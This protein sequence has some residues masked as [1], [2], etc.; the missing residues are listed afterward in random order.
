MDSRRKEGTRMGKKKPLVQQ[1]KDISPVPPSFENAE[2][3]RRSKG[4]L[5]KR[6]K[7]RKSL[8]N[9]ETR[10]KKGEDRGERYAPWSQKHGELK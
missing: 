4:D 2:R 8:P 1:E 9:K 5:M 3:R 10:G 7:D 6:K